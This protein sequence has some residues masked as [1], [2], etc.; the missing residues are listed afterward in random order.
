[1]PATKCFFKKSQQAMLANLSRVHDSNESFN[2]NESFE[3]G[4]ESS[5]TKKEIF[6]NRQKT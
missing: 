4:V 5:V 6:C 3:N 1:M 2:S